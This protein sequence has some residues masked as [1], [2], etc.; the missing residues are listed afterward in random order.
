MKRIR[1]LFHFK[2]YT[3]CLRIGTCFFLISLFWG[4]EKNKIE[5]NWNLIFFEDFTNTTDTINIWRTDFPW[6]RYNYNQ[7]YLGEQVSFKDGNAILNGIKKEFV[8][9]A[10][11]W[12]KT[13]DLLEDGR[14]NLRKF[15]YRSGMLF[16]NAKHKFGKFE[17]RCKIPKGNGLWP[18]FWLYGSCGEEIDIFEFDCEFPQTIHTA[19]HKKFFCSD[20]KTHHYPIRYNFP[21]DFSEDFNI[22][23]VEWTEKRIAWFVNGELL[24]EEIG[25]NDAVYLNSFPDSSLHLIVNLAITGNFVKSEPELKEGDTA[26]F[27]IDYIKIYN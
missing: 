8:G 20:G 4:C 11:P 27:I 26:K 6:F 3:I 24:R 1:S 17:I 25:F 2:Y 14:F 13:N 18:A 22:Y 21:N 9:K 5:K 23:A 19:R 15:D 7:I 10:V 12:R 16:L